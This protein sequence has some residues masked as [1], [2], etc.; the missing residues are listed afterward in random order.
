MM[1]E[2]L[3]ILAMICPAT[4]ALQAGAATVMRP[5]RAARQL[6][7]VMGEASTKKPNEWKYVKSVN[8]FGKEYAT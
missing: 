6:A 2:A 3:L 8:D 7:V 5:K 4:D 1:R